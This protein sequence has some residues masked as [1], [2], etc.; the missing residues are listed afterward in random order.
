MKGVGG[1]PVSIL[2]KVSCW[3][4]LRADNDSSDSIEMHND[5]YVPK[6]PFNILPPQLIFSNL[7]NNNYKVEWFKHDNRR[8]MLQY[9]GSGKEKKLT[10][11]IDDRNMF[12]LWMQFGYDAFTCRPCNNAAVWNDISGSTLIP[13]DASLPSSTPKSNPREPVMEQTRG[14]ERD[15]EQ[16]ERNAKIYQNLSEVTTINFNDNAFAPEPA[17]PIESD[18]TLL[19]SSETDIEEYLDIT[20]VHCNHHKLAVLHERFGHL[21]FSILKLM[22]RAGLI[23][24]ELS[25]V[26]SPTCTGC[27]YGKAHCKP[28]RRKGVRNRKSLKIATVPGQV[29]RVDQLV[30]PTPVLVPMHRGTTTTKRYIGATIFVDHFYNFTYAHLMTEMN[31]ETTVEAKLAFERV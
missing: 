7:K 19:P 9:S 10:I 11:L 23:P 31:A 3:V 26:D 28:C 16:R 4:N 21:S 25:N 8:Y 20:L 1:N 29:V 15:E 5:V 14:T 27:E 24:R 12:T 22:A 6:S 30:I 18:F 17:S 2:G 13:D